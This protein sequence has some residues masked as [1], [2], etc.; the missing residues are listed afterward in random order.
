MNPGCGVFPSNTYIFE[1]SFFNGLGVWQ[2]HFSSDLMNC[3]VTWS[4]L[5]CSNSS[6]PI[7][8][9]FRQFSSDQGTVQT[10][11][12][13]SKNCSNSSVPF[14]ELFRQFSS[15]QRTVQTVQFRSK[16][17]SNSSVPFKELFRQCSSD[18]GTVQ[19]VQFR[20]KN[21]WDSSEDRN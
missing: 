1:R 20:S 7:K 18:Q 6:V 12:F 4:D 17:C 21:L 8:E 2:F 16:N 15:V 5:H 14:K 19:T 9:L 13:R 10:V 3:S 11:Q